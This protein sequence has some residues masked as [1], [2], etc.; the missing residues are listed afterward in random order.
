MDDTLILFIYFSFLV[1]MSSTAEPSGFS[2]TGALLR[3]TLVPGAHGWV[4]VLG[5]SVG[6]LAP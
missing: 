1:I 5:G 3:G 4:A 2:V 6:F